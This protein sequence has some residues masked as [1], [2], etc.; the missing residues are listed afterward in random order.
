VSVPRRPIEGLDVAPGP[1]GVAALLDRLPDA[2]AGLGPALGI[3]P[4][5]DDEPAQRA[6]AAVRGDDVDADVSLVVATSGSTGRPRG[7][8]L[9]A[10]GLL[11]S[12]TAALERLGGPGAWLLALPVTSVGGLQVLVRSLLAQ[13]EP[14][15]L[16]S[17]GG[18][19][20]FSPAE[21]AAATWRL[22][23]SL[24]GYTSIVPAQAARLLDDEEGRDALRAY[25]AVLLGGARTAPVLLER[26]LDARVAAITTYG[27]TETSGGAVYD[28]VPLAGVEVRIVDPDPEGVGRIVVSGPTVARGYLSDPESTAATF[29]DGGVLTGDVGRRRDDLLEVLGRVDDVVQVGGVNV[30]VSAVADLLAGACVDA[31]VLASDDDAWGSL[32]TAYV[33]DPAPDD[34]ALASLVAAGLGRAAVPRRWVRLGSIPYLPN[35]KPDREAL[36][37]LDG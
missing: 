13:A 6:R 29:V 8:L 22:D 1:P 15:V 3:A 9:T 28:G 33:V 19:A 23:P 21:F 4:G 20:S 11:A 37:R 17:V 26:L 24:P 25:E 10:A 34:A 30:A 16:G 36:R 31:C 2:L 7:V 27:M 14:V 35:G 32:L 18:A 5:G 12:A